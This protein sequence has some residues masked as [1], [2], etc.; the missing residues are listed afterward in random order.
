MEHHGGIVS[1]E[2][3]KKDKPKSES[4]PTDDKPK[5]RPFTP[6]R[7]KTFARRGNEKRG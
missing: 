6:P 4:A 3:D 5:K 2:Q 1:T 7:G